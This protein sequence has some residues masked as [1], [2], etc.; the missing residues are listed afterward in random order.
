MTNYFLEE[1]NPYNKLKE[2]LAKEGRD[3]MDT[4][5]YDDMT[6]EE[7]YEKY[8]ST[9]EETEKFVQDIIDGKIVVRFCME[10]DEAIEVLKTHGKEGLNI[11]CPH[12][13]LN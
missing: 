5:K 3:I 7:L 4:S 2:R 10:Y 6:D 12:I 9:D 11:V 13:N 1:N 8:F